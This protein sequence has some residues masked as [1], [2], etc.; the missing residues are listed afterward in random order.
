MIFRVSKGN[1]YTTFNLVKYDKD[2]LKFLEKNEN[3]KEVYY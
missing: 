2:I 1:A 3:N